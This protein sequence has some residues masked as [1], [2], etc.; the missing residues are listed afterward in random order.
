[1]QILPPSPGS[2][3]WWKPVAPSW[4]HSS[5]RMEVMWQRIE[6]FSNS[7]HQ[8]LSEVSKAPWEW[9]LHQSGFQMTAVPVD[10]LT[11]TSR[12]TEPEPPNKPPSNSWSTETE[13][14]NV[15]SCFKPLHFAIICYTARDNSNGNILNREKNSVAIYAFKCTFFLAE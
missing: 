7:Q 6:V 8:L 11:A 3:L 2:S 15:Y 5:S 12:E 9:I 14:V 10:V 13:I 1:M 4:R